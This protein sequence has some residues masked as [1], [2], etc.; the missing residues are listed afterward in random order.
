MSNNVDRSQPLVTVRPALSDMPQKTVIVLGCPRGGTS[1]VAGVLS[2]LGVF[3]GD[4]L[5]HQYEDPRFREE[6]SLEEKINAISKNNSLYSTWGWKLPNTIYYID[7][8]IEHIRNP[9]FIAIYRNPFDIFL[10]STRHD[11]EEINMRNMEV[12]IDHYKIMNNV[13]KQYG[14]IPLATCSFE[15]VIWGGWNRR[16]R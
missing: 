7:N 10:S 5:G 6:T 15:K 9:V 14:D 16:W 3:M 13:L 1:L 2:R 4:G 12:P 11:D 8:I